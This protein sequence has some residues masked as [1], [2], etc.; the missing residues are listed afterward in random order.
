MSIRYELQRASNSDLGYRFRILE[1][2]SRPVTGDRYR[3]ATLLT[4]AKA[5][6]RL[7][8]ELR[9]NAGGD[10]IGLITC[11][12]CREP[13]GFPCIEPCQDHE[14]RWTS[15]ITYLCGDCAT[16]A[17]FCRGCGYFWAGVE[18]FDFSRIRG[19]C[20]DCVHDLENEF[21]DGED[22]EYFDPEV[23]CDRPDPVSSEP[24]AAS[25]DEEVPF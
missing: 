20:S 8:R 13:G 15:E 6:R 25:S 1:T 24:T 4:T 7:L 17:G 16:K 19:Y 22:E 5:A 21:G 2:R 11:L 12:E 9:L 14:S 10:Q 18:S 3:S 23:E